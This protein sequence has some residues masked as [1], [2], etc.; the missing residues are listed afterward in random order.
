[1]ITRRNMLMGAITGLALAVGGCSPQP[2]PV[3]DVNPNPMYG[4]VNLSDSRTGYTFGLVVDE[5]RDGTPDYVTF[6]PRTGGNRILYVRPGF[7]P[8]S[9]TFVVDQNTKVMDE[10]MAKM[11]GQAMHYGNVFNNLRHHPNTNNQ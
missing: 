4:C 7:Q 2:K 11:A 3:A 5:D 9:E 6:D 8:K 10:H 1:M